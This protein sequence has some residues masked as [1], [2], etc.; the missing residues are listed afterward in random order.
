[1]PGTDRRFEIDC[2]REQDSGDRERSRCDPIPVHIGPV[3]GHATSQPAAEAT[4]ELDG[5]ERENAEGR[6]K[7]EPAAVVHP[8]SN[9]VIRRL[10]GEKTTGT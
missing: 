3:V 6:G 10:A 4:V 5:A 2:G 1:M 8:Q 7:T 9:V